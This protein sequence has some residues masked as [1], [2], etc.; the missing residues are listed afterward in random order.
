M[1]ILPTPFS[2]IFDGHTRYRDR[3]S[4]WV[5]VSG[6]QDDV[7]VLHN[8][9]CGCNCYGLVLFIGGFMA[10][11]LER[12]P[13]TRCGNKDPLWISLLCF[14]FK[15][16]QCDFPYL[17]TDNA[18]S[19]NSCVA[20]DCLNLHPKYE[21]PSCEF[22]VRVFFFFFK[23]EMMNETRYRFSFSLIIETLLFVFWVLGLFHI[24]Q[25]PAGCSCLTASEFFELLFQH[26]ATL[27]SRTSCVLTGD[28]RKIAIRKVKRIKS[29]RFPF[30]R[31]LC[32]P[33]SLTRLELFEDSRWQTAQKYEY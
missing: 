8:V 15:W 32:S 3:R 30:E 33:T 12:T 9:A 29:F 10:N 4:G 20:A 28:D 16:L 14:C 1:L 5:D 13:S 7:E 26:D 23:H 19:W 11:I 2:S 31:A 22:F 18:N 17:D 21:Q 24:T 27:S 6:V 25:L